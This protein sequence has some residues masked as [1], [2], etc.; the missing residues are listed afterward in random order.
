MVPEVQTPLQRPDTGLPPEKCAYKSL[1]IKYFHG[2]YARNQP[3]YLRK[4][5]YGKVRTHEQM[6]A[7]CELYPGF[8]RFA[9]LLESVAQGIQDGTI[10]VPPR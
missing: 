6:D 2:V 8:Y 7:L 5:R 3:P 10:E 9:K 1:R 4:S